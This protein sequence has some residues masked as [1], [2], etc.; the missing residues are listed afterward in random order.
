M[1]ATTEGMFACARE[2]LRQNPSATDEELR[3]ALHARF[4]RGEELFAEAADRGLE[5]GAL[6][7]ENDS[8]AG[9]TAIFL[10]LGKLLDRNRRPVAERVEMVLRVV[11]EEREG[12]GG[13]V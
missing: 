4:V 9:V 10:R 8:L 11:R 12:A 2:Q 6:A 7:N 1:P 5:A 13:G 3:T